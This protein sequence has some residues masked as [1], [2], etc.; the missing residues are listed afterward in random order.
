MDFSSPNESPV[1]LADGRKLRPEDIHGQRQT[2]I[3]QARPLIFMNACR[4][5]QQAW[6]L[7][8][9]GGWA[10]AWVDRCRCGVFVG[11]LW[12]VNDRLAYEFAQAFYDALRAKQTIGQAALAARRHVR[13]LAPDDPNCL[14][15]SVY[16]HPNARVK[17][18][19]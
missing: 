17:F 14:A 19:A 13:A 10:S 4:V 8:R 18:G 1:V 9:L 3:A 6:A 7:T 5:G 11:P 16:A 15:Y 12:S 2:H